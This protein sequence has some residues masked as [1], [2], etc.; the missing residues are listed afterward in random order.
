MAG[1]PAGG[2]TDR[3]TTAISVLPSLT[4]ACRASLFCGELT[5]GEQSVEQSGFAALVKAPRA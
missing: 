2:G 5:T 1:V 4:K 3:R